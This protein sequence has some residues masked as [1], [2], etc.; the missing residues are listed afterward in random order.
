MTAVAAIKTQ[1]TELYY[2]SGPSA[3]T[4]IAQITSAPSPMG[5]ARAQ[6]DI[7][8][9]DSA[10]HEYASGLASPVAETFGIIFNAKD[11]SHQALVSLKTSGLLVPWW[12]GL[13]DGAIA[14][15]VTANA[16][17]LTPVARSFFTFLGYVADLVLATPINDVIKGTIT[18][19]RSGPSLLTPST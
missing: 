5:G 10:E 1:G 13:S 3:A 8:T 9:L 19:Q 7:T 17:V 18:I 11:T 6:I 2:A 14:P 12:V 15:T 16:F 4:K